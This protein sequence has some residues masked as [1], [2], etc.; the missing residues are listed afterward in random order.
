MKGERFDSP[1]KPW[2]GMEQIAWN[3]DGSKIAYTCKKLVGK[4]WTVSTNSNIYIYDLNTKNHQPYPDNPGYDQ[5]P[6]FSPDGR[7]IVWH[8]MATP[9]FEADKQRIMVH[10][11]ESGITR[12]YSI[13]FDQS[14]IGFAWSADSKTIYFVSGIQATYQVYELILNPVRSARSPMAITTTKVWLLPAMICLLEP[15]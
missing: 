3:H 4:D 14:S 9:G 8:S 10:D 6:V 13:D 2:G 15:K 11:F 5:D 1:M 7:M 12:D